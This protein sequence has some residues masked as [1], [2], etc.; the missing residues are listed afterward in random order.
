MARPHYPRR[1]AA[2][3]RVVYFKPAG[4]PLREIAEIEL[5]V[6]E[7]E[8]LRLAD[9]EGLYQTDGAR[10]MGISRAT[11]ARIVEASRRKVAEAL[12]HGRALRIGGGPVEFAGERRFRCES[13][14][15]EWSAPFGTGRPAGCPGCGSAAFLRTDRGPRG[16]RAGAAHGRRAKRG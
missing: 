15:K 11:F 16:G 12:V 9:L 8:A 7:F 6:D 10:R 13:C 3:P 2:P 1:V 14:R 5:T 4:V